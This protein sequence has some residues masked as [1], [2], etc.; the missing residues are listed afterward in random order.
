MPRRPPHIPQKPKRIDTLYLAH[1]TFEPKESKTNPKIPQLYQ[2]F[3]KVFS[4]E[5]SH[6]FPPARVWDHA[7]ELK[8][9]APATLPGKIYPLSQT[10][11]QELQKF[12][13]EHLKLGTIRLSKSPY[14]ASFFFIKKKDGK[15]RPVQD[16][17][18]IN[19]WTI[20]NH[21]PLPLIPQLI[22][23]LWGCS[24]FTKFDV[25][26]GYNNVRIKDGDQWKAAFITN[27]G[28]FEPTIMFFGLTNSPATFQMMMNTIFREE[29]AQG[30]LTIYMDNMA[31][32]TGP[33]EVETSQQHQDRHRQW[34]KQVLTT[35]QK[36]N[37]FLK[38]EK[39][40]FKQKEI[41]FLG[42]KVNYRQV[43]MDEHKVQKAQEWP[44][45]T[46]VTEVRQFLGFTG[47]Y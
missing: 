26:W 13:D 23:R 29:M 12:V 34:V 8:P 28:L 30:W 20:R 31:I 1:V 42:I 16:Y 17:R 9:D 6:K 33:K 22:D 27:Q 2:Q 44:E 11:L 47:F 4:E 46:S 40:S 19:H 35:L 15:L 39:C 38:P 41:E 24:L 25:C 36:H 14:A 43:C 32:H 37:L 10:E 5:A 7:I 45:P 3:T 21:Y 18:P